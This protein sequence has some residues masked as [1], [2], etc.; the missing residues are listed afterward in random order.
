MD[1]LLLVGLILCFGCADKK[2]E[3]KPNLRQPESKIHNDT[4][5]ISG[6]VILKEYLGEDGKL[7][8]EEEKTYF[9]TVDHKDILLEIKLKTLNSHVVD[10]PDYKLNVKM[11]KSTAKKYDKSIWEVNNTGQTPLGV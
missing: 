4:F 5:K 9:E 6:Q 10:K 11:L 7:V 3:S 8:T 2:S 1:K